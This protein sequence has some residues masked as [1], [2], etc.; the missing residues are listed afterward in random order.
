LALKEAV[1]SVVVAATSSL[2][3]SATFAKQKM[4]KAKNATFSRNTCIFMLVA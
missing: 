2:H 3:I 1:V 4:Q